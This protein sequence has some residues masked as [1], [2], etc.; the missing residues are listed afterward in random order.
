MAHQG[1]DHQG[2]LLEGGD[3][4]I[5]SD[6]RTGGAARLP[7]LAVHADLATGPTRN[8]DLGGL[9]DHRLWTGLRPPP[10][11]Q[12]AAPH[13]LTNLGDHT[14][15]HHDE[16]PRPGDEQ[17]GDD[18]R[19]DQDHARSILPHPAFGLPAASIGCGGRIG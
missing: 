5:L 15:K 3:P 8:H 6:V 2:E 14:A 12:P 19:E 7:E 17:G 9:A 13:D 18:D 10:P 11:C 16:V 1:L 4:H